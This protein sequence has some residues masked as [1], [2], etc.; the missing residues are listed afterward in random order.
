MTM[1]H[2]FI[3]LDRSGSMSTVWTEALSSINAYVQKLADDKVDTGVTLA[4][5]DK[6]G[7]EF[8]FEVIRDRIIPGTWKLGNFRSP[9]PNAT[10][11]SCEH[12]APSRGAH[13]HRSFHS[14]C[15]PFV[16]RE[17]A[18]VFCLIAS[19]RSELRYGG[20]VQRRNRRVGR[21]IRSECD[22]WSPARRSRLFGRPSIP[23]LVGFPLSAREG[24]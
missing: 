4:T 2:D 21:G 24:S 13:R 23:L 17:T 15:R 3:L 7:A 1:Q 8:K 11:A 19:P 20:I 10:H 9:L 12:A 6:D 5:F 22:P 18:P 14:A 16:G